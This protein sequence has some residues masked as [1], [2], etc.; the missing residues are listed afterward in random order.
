MHPPV[1]DN[2]KRVNE[3]TSLWSGCLIDRY[4]EDLVD[5][6]VELYRV[7]LLLGML[8]MAPELILPLPD[9]LT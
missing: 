2:V 9:L 5:V 6:P 4:V 1:Q 3:I 7:F 8:L